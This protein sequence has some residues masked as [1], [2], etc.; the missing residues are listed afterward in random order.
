MSARE[1]LRELIV[2]LQSHGL[3]LAAAQEAGRQGGAGPANGN[4]I[5]FGD[6]QAV[7][8]T[9]GICAV[10]SPYTMEESQ[11]GLLIKKGGMPVRKVDLIRRPRYYSLKTEDGIPYWKIALLHGKNCLGSTV[12]QSCVRWNTPEQ[13]KF[14]SIGTSLAEGK[15]I[16]VKT[17][18]Q[19]AAVAS[20]ALRLDGLKHVALTAG[21]TDPPDEGIRYLGKCAQAIKMKTQLPVHVQFE[22]PA[23]MDICYELREAGVDTVGIHVE[24]FDQSVRGNIT[25]GKA[26]TALATYFAAME[27]A[28]AVFGKNQV[29]SFVI[30]GLG[31]DRQTIVDGCKKC[32]ALG[33]YPFIVPFKPLRGSHMENCSMPESVTVAGIYEEVS[34]CLA[35]Q[36]LSYHK[37][38]AGCVR[39]GACSTL[40]AFER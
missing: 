6:Y 28:V 36:G 10:N 15:T 25:P 35:E 20:A 19:L 40:P 27:K 8:P 1:E 38:K 32:I 21:T 29:S 7:V 34:G 14:C 2:E 17:P 5:D 24:S 4:A 13:C 26:K 33:V 31:E 16:S 3:K 39:C 9:T 23:N 18:E 22:P 12:I 37:N 30:V 11:D